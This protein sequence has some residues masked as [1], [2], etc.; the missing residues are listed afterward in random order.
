MKKNAGFTLIELLVVIGILSLLMVAILPQL[1]KAT[2]TTKIKICS[3]HLRDLH[4]GVVNIYSQAGRYPRGEGLE[5]LYNVWKYGFDHNEKGRD[6]MFCPV[7]DEDE[8]LT[9]LLELEPDEIWRSLDEFPSEMTNYAAL[10]KEA[11]GRISSGKTVLFADDNEYG[12][13]HRDG[14]LNVVYGDGST[15]TFTRQYL[16]E[17][18]VYSSQLANPEDEEEVLIVGPDSQLPKLRKLKFN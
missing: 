4:Q 5:L 17:K 13:N 18:G 2:L 14:S 3:M 10:T 8:A 6:T 7:I 16:E 12:N 11:K 1:S 9:D 15:V